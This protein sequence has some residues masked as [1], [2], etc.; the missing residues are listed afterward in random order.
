[1]STWHKLTSDAQRIAVW[2][3]RKTPSSPK[4]G[5]QYPTT[6]IAYF[7]SLRILFPPCSIL[8]VFYSLR[9]LF[10]CI[11]TSNYANAGRYQECM[12]RGYVIFPPEWPGP[13]LLSKIHALVS[14]RQLPT[15]DQGKSSVYGGV[16]AFSAPRIG[17]TKTPI[18]AKTRKP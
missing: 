1:M 16:C 6:P 2:S 5:S 7:H 4:L 18:G 8:S 12:V 13:T 3:F 14:L 9:I 11:L 10:P 15:N 17:K